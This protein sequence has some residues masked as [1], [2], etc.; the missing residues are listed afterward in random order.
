M[1]IFQPSTKKVF[2][3]LF[4]V[5]L[6]SSQSLSTTPHK[7]FKIKV[8]D[9]ETGRGIPLV[10]IRTQSWIR[11][12]T[13]SNGLVAFYEPSLMDQDSYL[14][15]ESEGYAYSKD[16]LG[17]SG[18]VINP[19]KNDSIVVKMRRVNIAERLYRI[20][21]PG[22][23]R[24]SY[25]FGISTPLKN[26][27][28]NGKVLG[29]DSNL[30]LKYKGNIFWIWGDTFKPSYPWGNFSISAATSKL[31]ENGGLS[32]AI[33]VDLNYFV[34]STGFSKSM[35]VLEGKGFVWF[36]WLM[37]IPDETGR[38]KLVAKYARVKTDFTNHERGI[39]VYNDQ[40]EIFEKYKQIDAWIAEYNCTHHP[41]RAK[42][43]GRE[44][45]ILTSEF[46][47]SRVEPTLAKVSDPAAYESFTCL[48]Q[49][50]KYNKENPDLDRDESGK[51]IWDWKIN[52][53]LI[54]LVR[55]NELVETNAIQEQE[56]WLYFQDIVNGESLPFRRGSIYWNDYRQRWILIVQKDMGE[57]W[58]AEGDTPTGPWV[59]AKKVLTHNQYFYNPVHH[60][61][62]DQDSGKTIYFEGTY[63]N[64]FNANPVIKPRYEYNQLM[65]R[66]VLDDPKLFLPVP[67]Y[68][69][70]NPD[71]KINYQLKESVDI[72]NSWQSILSANFFAFPPDRPLNSLIP[73][74][75][76]SNDLGSILSTTPKGELLFYA[77]PME[78]IENEKFLGTWYCKMTDGLFIN[79]EFKV[80]LQSEKNQLGATIDDAGYSLA[81][82]RT[83]KDMIYFTLHYVDKIYQFTAEVDSGRIKGSWASPD[84]AFTGTWESENT[85]HH[86]QPVHSPLLA[87]LYVYTN[88]KSSNWFYSVDLGPEYQSY[89]RS[90]VAICRVWKNPATNIEIEP[91]INAEK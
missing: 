29:Q 58:Y 91:A 83:E 54:D 71:N 39:A 57:I 24:D 13:D 48:K 62:F 4:I 36:D 35:I 19:L 15:I 40:K 61:F 30:S 60:P 88:N 85:D 32:P 70:K 38:E 27:L 2:I 14:F 50:T 86:W 89:S 10:E 68:Q 47:F 76:T 9:E 77:L 8:I 31:P 78:K 18:F 79:Q 84:S 20:T 11:Y 22:I 75:L 49:G 80:T 6:F 52:T 46:A 56:K 23:Y 26:P 63:T 12:F 74:Y 51:L 28:L 5:F 59:F 87:P 69:V 37:T 65:Y 25:I 81:N 42:I 82:L 44:Y 33:G 45:A 3:H 55:Q 34:D 90:D 1:I 66:L 73:I 17:N 41:I 21:G 16:I 7:Y 43:D 72:N 67:V 64:I 53:D